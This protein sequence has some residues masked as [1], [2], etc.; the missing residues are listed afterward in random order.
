[1]NELGPVPEDV[2]G[3]RE[4]TMTGTTFGLGATVTRGLIGRSAAS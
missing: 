2:P 1:M 4:A 3:E